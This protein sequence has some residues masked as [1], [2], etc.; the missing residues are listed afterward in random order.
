[1]VQTQTHGVPGPQSQQP[2]PHIPQHPPGPH[3]Q[4]SP[5]GGGPGGPGGGG[6]PKQKTEG[7]E[8]LFTPMANLL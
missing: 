1:M 5:G 4:Q 8:L 6:G 7:P 2:G 3:P